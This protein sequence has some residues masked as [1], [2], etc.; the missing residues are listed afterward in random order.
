MP[1]AYD[2]IYAVLEPYLFW[3]ANEHQPSTASIHEANRML[4]RIDD[5]IGPADGMPKEPAMWLRSQVENHKDVWGAQWA[6][7]PFIAFDSMH[8]SSLDEAL[9]NG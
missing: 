7:V 8:V 3:I 5:V 4:A 9:K 6:K 2:A 1:P